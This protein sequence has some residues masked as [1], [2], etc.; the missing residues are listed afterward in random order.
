MFKYAKPTIPLGL[1]HDIEELEPGGSY[2]QANNQN[3]K[4]CEYRSCGLNSGSPRLCK[5]SC[6]S[7]AITDSE[8]S[9]K[10]CLK[11]VA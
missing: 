3:L 9:R 2:D 10:F 1:L 7:C 6:R 4:S 8:E 11:F 5:S